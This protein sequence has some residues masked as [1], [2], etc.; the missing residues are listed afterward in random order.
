MLVFIYSLGFG[1]IP[2]FAI[3]HRKDGEKSEYHPKM[4]VMFACPMLF[5]SILRLLRHFTEK[6][7][8]RPHSGKSQGIRNLTG[9]HCLWSKHTRP[10]CDPSKPVRL[11]PWLKMLTSWKGNANTLKVISALHKYFPQLLKSSAML[12]SFTLF[13]H[14]RFG[15]SQTEREGVETVGRWGWG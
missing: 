5:P 11:P 7:R 9:I 13:M 12:L 2:T 8:C 15:K 6:H 1:S 10:H 3:L 14:V 4:G